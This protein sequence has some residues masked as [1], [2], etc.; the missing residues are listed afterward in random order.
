MQEEMPKPYTPRENNHVTPDHVTPDHV[1]PDAPSG[2]DI[3]NNETSVKSVKSGEYMNLKVIREDSIDKFKIKKYTQLRKLM[4]AYCDRQGFQRSLV[5]FRF[6][7]KWLKETDTPEIL[8]MEDEDALEA[9]VDEKE[10]AD[11]L[12]KAP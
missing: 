2:Y 8:E 3:L 5:K 6:D 11:S 4:K 10:S 12:E 1:T 9:W 7:G